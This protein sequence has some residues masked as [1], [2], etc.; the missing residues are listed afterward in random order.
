MGAY[1]SVHFNCSNCN[2]LYHIVKA[3]AEPETKDREITCRACGGLLKGPKGNF[4]F[5]YFLLR[6]AIRVD[7]RA[8]AGSQRHLRLER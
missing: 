3:E 8:R 6:K 2:G 7:P 1:V 4:V 5:K